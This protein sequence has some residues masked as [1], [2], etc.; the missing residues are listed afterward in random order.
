MVYFCANKHKLLACTKCPG[1]VNCPVYTGPVKKF[2]PQPKQAP[3]RACQ[4]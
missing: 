4:K 1:S 3:V 2:K